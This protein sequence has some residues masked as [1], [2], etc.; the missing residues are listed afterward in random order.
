M[1]WS[2]EDRPTFA[3]SGAILANSKQ[4]SDGVLHRVQLA[5]ML[6]GVA[7]GLG[8]RLSSQLPSELGHQGTVEL[9]LDLL[10]KGAEVVLAGLIHG[11]PWPSI[12]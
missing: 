1:L 5:P 3:T 8:G 4:V 2:F 7:E 11:Y 10:H 6:P 12:Y 9:R